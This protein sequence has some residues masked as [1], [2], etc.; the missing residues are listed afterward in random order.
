MTPEEENKIKELARVSTGKKPEAR[1]ENSDIAKL[2]GNKD[3]HGLTNVG[4]SPGHATEQGGETN[5]AS[6]SVT[7]DERGSVQTSR[8][9]TTHGS[10][11]SWNA[12]LSE[13]RVKEKIDENVEGSVEQEGSQENGEQSMDEEGAIR[14]KVD[15]QNE[16]LQAERRQEAEQFEEESESQLTTVIAS[17]RIMRKT[18]WVAAIGGGTVGIGGLAYFTSG[19]DST[20]FIH[21]I[22]HLIA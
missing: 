1:D 22:R 15:E 9:T 5:N 2:F 4:G 6:A 10:G 12:H 14:Q 18:G 11:Y 21:V 19:S 8:D 13:N 17:Q 16:R 20:A 3:G 7:E